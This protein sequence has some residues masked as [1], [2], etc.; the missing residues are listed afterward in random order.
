[1]PFTSFSEFNKGEGGDVWFALDEM[2]PLAAVAGI[3]TNWTS[4]RKVK[5]GET[6]N[7]LLGFLTTDANNFMKP[8][9]SK[10]MPV[11]LREEA[12]IERRMTASAEDA[13]KLQRPLPHEAQDRVARHKGRRGAEHTANM[14]A[15]ADRQLIRGSASASAKRRA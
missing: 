9:H 10:A 11:I 2:R 3:G 13:L 6:T 7:D 5:A 8:I 14:A 12:E 4:V 15:G 1:M